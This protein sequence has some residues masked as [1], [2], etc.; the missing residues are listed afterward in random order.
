MRRF[1]AVIFCAAAA[2]GGRP[3]PVTRPA[4]PTPLPTV[5]GARTEAP[6]PPP[7]LPPEP[8]GPPEGYVEM[9]ALRVA[10]LP[11][12]D[13][14]L[15]ADPA[16]TIILPIF[17]G[18]TEALS[19]QLRLA[20]EPYERP[21]THDLVDSVVE[22][23]GGTIARAQVDE[24][25]GSTFIGSLWIRREGRLVKLDARPSDAIAMAI[26]AAVP[27]YV[28]RSVMDAAGVPVHSPAAPPGAAPPATVPPPPGTF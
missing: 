7:P 27:I 8:S 5:A 24:L 3:A 11:Q 15:L 18:G 1:A 9:R 28:A 13:A 10:P 21:L 25:R 23:L 12:G 20:H 6:R 14:V 26:G 17:V 4:A 16:E 2:C 19:I 22:E